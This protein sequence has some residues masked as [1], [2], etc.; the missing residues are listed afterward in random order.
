METPIIGGLLQ[1]TTENG[2]PFFEMLIAGKKYLGLVNTLKDEEGQPDFLV[3]EDNNHS[4]KELSDRLDWDVSELWAV[5][6]T[7]MIL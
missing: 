4:R 5:H 6:K 3:I 2:N 1:Q 7:P